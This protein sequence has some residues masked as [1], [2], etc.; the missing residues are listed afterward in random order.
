MKNRVVKHLGPRVIFGHGY[1]LFPQAR[2]QLGPVF[3]LQS[4]H[5]G[6]YIF[7]QF[8]LEVLLRGGP[9]IHEGGEPSVWC[10]PFATV[11]FPF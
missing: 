2:I 7:D 6:R 3:T 11:L 5:F 10:F 9:L 8:G 1:R 4:P